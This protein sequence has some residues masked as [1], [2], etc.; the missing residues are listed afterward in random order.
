MM[1]FHPQT[2]QSPSHFSPSS[3]DQST[4][5]SG[6]MIST[7]T[8]LPTPAHS[9][10]GSSLANDMSFTDI[11]MGENSPQKRKRTA[12]DVGDRE[13]KKVHIE[14][15]KLGIDDLHL[16]VGEKYLLCRSQ[17]QP[18]RPHLSEDLFEMFGLADLAAEYA[19]IKDGQKNALRKTYKGHIKKL[20]VQGHFDS[21][22]TDEKDPERIE[23]L[24]ACPQEEWNAHFVRGKEITRGFSSDMKSKM[25]RAVTMSRG[26]V[27]STLWNNSVLGDIAT[28]SLKAHLNQP[29]SA[30]PTAPN[31]PLAYGGPA[32]QRVKPQTP[33]FQDNRPRRNI[34]KRGYGDSSFEGYGEGYEDDGGLETGYSTGEGDMASGFKRRKKTQP[35]TQSYAQGRQQSGYGHHGVSGI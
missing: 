19:R 20:G 11:V 29:P 9:V 6:S 3:S 8:T 1:S 32:M 12:D 28:T 27:P 16:D 26:T 21:V 23:Y 13:Q 30:R 35:G 4:S 18:P 24:M 25:S 15:R 22:K 14:D 5:M 34:K 7:T 33:G 31:T 17:H 2:P 10:N